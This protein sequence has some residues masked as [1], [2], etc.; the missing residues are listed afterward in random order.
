[1]GTIFFLIFH[2]IGKLLLPGKFDTPYD[3]VIF[4]GLVSFDSLVVLHYLALRK[5]KM[6]S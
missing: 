2:F 6:S 4:C 1:M 5:K 3:F